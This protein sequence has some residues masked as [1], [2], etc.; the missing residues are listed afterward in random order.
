VTVTS[1]AART[2]SARSLA[3]AYQ[4]AGHL[5]APAALRV[6]GA[7]NH[8]F[9]VGLH[10]GTLVAAGVAAAAAVAVVAL[11]P[12]RADSSAGPVP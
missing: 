7:A 5:S 2:T 11:L 6:T 12:A 9:L 1:A 8:A 4:V 3:A 10:A